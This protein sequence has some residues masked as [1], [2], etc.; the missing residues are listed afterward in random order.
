MGPW[1]V[2]PGRAV[3]RG[4][5]RSVVRP[6]EECCAGRCWSGVLSVLRVLNARLKLKVPS[7]SK[8]ISV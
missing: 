3:V 5:L 1:L 2:G 6:Y 8:Q 7:Y 4:V